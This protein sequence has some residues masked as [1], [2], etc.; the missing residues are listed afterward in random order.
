MLILPCRVDEAMK[1]GEDVSVT[2]LGVWRNQVL[3]VIGEP[4]SVSIHREEIYSQR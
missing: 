3:I 1:L 4:K 2:V